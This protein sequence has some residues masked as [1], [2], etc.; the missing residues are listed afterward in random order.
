MKSAPVTYALGDVHGCYDSLQALLARL[1][2]DPEVDHLWMVGDLINRGP[3]SL[4]TLRWAR[5]LE[6]QMGERFQLVLGN[7]DLHL[8]SL[9]EGLLEPG[10]K[11]N[12]DKVLAARDG[13][14]LVAWLRVRPL[15]HRR[16][17][18]LLVHAGLDPAWTARE[19]EDRARRVEAA[20]GRRKTLRQLLGGSVPRKQRSRMLTLRRDLATFTRLRMLTLKRK[21]CRFS[22]P[23]NKAPKGCMPW[24][25]HPK[26]RTRK[27]QVVFGHWAALGL[28]LQP[29]IFALDS[30]C[31]WGNAL[32]AVR[33][34][35]GA[36]FQ[37]PTVEP[38]ARLPPPPKR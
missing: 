23:P 19:A 22:G 11:T 9:S 24:F 21:P 10:R 18:W 38:A 26:R 20:L 7:H 12:L 16:G 17:P 29:G 14:E 31:L 25:S 33:L 5:D 34:E 15:L 3:K 8:L 6:A 13:A 28:H 35:D 30:G 27:K 1:P 4:K 2:F 36:L 37:Q 32:T